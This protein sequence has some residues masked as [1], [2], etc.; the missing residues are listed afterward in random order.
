MPPM[1]PAGT[2]PTGALAGLLGRS[3]H[4]LAQLR[5]PPTDGEWDC[6][7]ALAWRRYLYTRGRAW[8]SRVLELRPGG[9][10]GGRVGEGAAAR[11][12][13]WEVF[14]RGDGRPILVLCADEGPADR[15]LTAW[16]EAGTDGTWRGRWVVHE[17]GPVEMAPLSEAPPAA[18]DWGRVSPG[19]AARSVVAGL[20][21]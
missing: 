21:P 11:E 1:W 2:N 13:R 5:W 3:A 15:R 19:A 8:A 14:D 17:G 7:A 16:L 10:A 4:P 6:A 9:G 12:M 20:C 18:A